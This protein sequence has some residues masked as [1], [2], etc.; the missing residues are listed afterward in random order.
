M[1]INTLTTVSKWA[2]PFLLLV[3]PLY[4][5]LRRVPVYEAFVEGAEEGFTTAVKIIPFLVGMMLAISVF[6]ASGAM[7]LLSWCLSPLIRLLDIP[8]EILPL[9]I[10]RP[11]SG[12]AVLGMTTELMKA[13][14]P[15]SFIGRL[16][17]VMQGTTDTT[18]FILTIYFGS[19]G[20]KK[21][22]YSIITGL[23]ADITGFI[24]AIYICH[25]LFK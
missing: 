8:A 5:A 15:D 10:M 3:I 9:G 24:A 1:L 2:I 19:V 18:F 14:G 12:S 17:S 25:L 6:R 11:L 22:R 4:G 7:N 21:Y 20:I 23:S 16:A 13:Y